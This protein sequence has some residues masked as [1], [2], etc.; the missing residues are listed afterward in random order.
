M[1]A[2]CA[3]LSDGVDADN[4]TD[5]ISWQ[6]VV[7][8]EARTASELCKLARDPADF[9]ATLTEES[10][11]GKGA[12]GSEL[13]VAAENAAAPS[14]RRDETRLEAAGSWS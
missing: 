2:L 1:R 3:L 8:L 11:S 7:V 4:L 10:T 12:D 13:S 6:F 14:N 9:D 5:P